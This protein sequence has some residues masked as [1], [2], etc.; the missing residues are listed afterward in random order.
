MMLG[1]MAVVGAIVKQN[2]IASSKFEYAK[3]KTSAVVH[4]RH[5]Q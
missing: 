4:W 5:R 1:G 3:V 2:E